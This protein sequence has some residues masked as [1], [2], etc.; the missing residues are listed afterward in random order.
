MKP[1]KKQHQKQSV[2]TVFNRNQKYFYTE[3]KQK[4]NS[5]KTSEKNNK[6]KSLKNLNR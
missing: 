6:L 1:K 2:Y 5:S 4:K 3:P